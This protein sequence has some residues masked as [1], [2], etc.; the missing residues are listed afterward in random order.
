MHPDK[1]I[2]GLKRT[3]DFFVAVKKP[4]IFILRMQEKVRVKMTEKKLKILNVFT[5]KTLAFLEETC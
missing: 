5:K 3:G 2:S 4:E 1:N